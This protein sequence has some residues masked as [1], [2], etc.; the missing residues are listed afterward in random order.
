MPP[1]KSGDLSVSVNP[2]YH[3]WLSTRDMARIG[4]LMLRQ[5]EWNG[6]QLIPTE[7]VRQSTSLL[8]P[9]S[10]MHPASAQR[11]GMGYGYLWWIVEA[12]AESPLAG[13]YSARGAVGQY[14]MVIPKLDLVIAHK[15]AVGDGRTGGNAGVSW[16]QFMGAVERVLAARCPGSCPVP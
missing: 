9:S 5:G 11:R 15:R 14:I 4:Y 3:M 16:P 7:W 6:R 2:A 13:S 1:R 12:P 8:V 10:A